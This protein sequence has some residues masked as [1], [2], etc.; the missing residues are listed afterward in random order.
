MI[1]AAVERAS[2]FMNIDVV[3]KLKFPSFRRA[4]RKVLPDK[5]DKL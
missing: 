1:P 4:V 2:V 5:C 3:R